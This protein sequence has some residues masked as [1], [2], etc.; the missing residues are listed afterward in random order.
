[1]KRIICV[2]TAVLL[3][4]CALSIPAFA[5]SASISLSKSSVSVGSNVTVSVKYNASFAMYAIDA[6][7][8]YN[9]SVLQYVSGGT[10]QGSTV[11]IVETLSG[12]TSKSFSVT[13][14]TI[15]AG[16]GSVSFSAKASGEGDGSASA[17]T[18]VTVTAPQPSS[19]ANLSSIK[20]SDGT[21]S[22]AFKAA[23]TSYSAKV[24][25]QTEKIT[26]SA[27]AA[28]GDS[29]V[30]GAGTFNLK[31]GDNSFNLT[32]T[33]ASGDKKTYTVTVKRMSE[34]E[35]ASALKE[36]RDNNPSLIVVDGADYFIQSDVSSLG[37]IEGFTASSVQRKGAD[38]SVLADNAG[39]YKLFWATD[40]NGENGAF[41]TADE[42]DNFTR[43]D[44][45][46]L[47]DKLYIIEP[48]EDGI[49]V[50]KDFIAGEYEIN[51]KKIACYKYADEELSDFY[52]FY[53]YVNGENGYYRF[54][55]AQNTI[56]REPKFLAKEVE[57]AVSE[58]KTGLID[59]FNN[60]SAQAKIVLCL[61]AFAA[62]LVL[63][64]IVLLIVRAVN[65]GKRNT[66]AADGEDMVLDDLLNGDMFEPSEPFEEEKPEIEFSEDEETVSEEPE[67]VEE[68]TPLNETVE[69]AFL[70]TDDDD[71]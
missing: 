42:Q 27:N 7:I 49:N 71:F 4:L 68:D 66:A 24:K 2:F 36:E 28:A 63:V 41:F 64:L 38:I 65:R 9:S 56:Q 16:S 3:T 45:I 58:K 59:R 18:S 32:V 13:F 57:E 60:L 20:L 70:E 35:T 21:L 11:K 25:Y 50:S 39:K 46:K 5:D 37:P 34:E 67:T 55:A 61:L 31:V 8:T 43:I 54:D 10:N 69:D 23:T 48:F 30:S 29:V 6:S 47:S 19:N 52:V 14:K 15:A 1:M 33:A 40:A 51:G 17:G 62:L 53:C 26:I 44:Y 22:P 12:E